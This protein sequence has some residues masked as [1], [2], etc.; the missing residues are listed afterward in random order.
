M[1]TR[2][3]GATRANR[4]RTRGLRPGA[5]FDGVQVFTVTRIGEFSRMGERATA[6]LAAHRHDVEPTELRVVQ[7]SCA[8][9]RLSLCVFWRRRTRT[10]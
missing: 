10:S 2:R 5:H 7:S 1:M 6:W 9:Y 4:S 8:V 3:L